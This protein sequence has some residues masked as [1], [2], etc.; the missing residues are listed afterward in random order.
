MISFRLPPQFTGSRA[1]TQTLDAYIKLRR[2]TNSVL[3][4]LSERNTISELTSAQFAVLEALYHLGTLMQGMVTL[5]Q[6][7]YL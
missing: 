4:R 3:A 2:D 5:K 6:L 1:E 7:N